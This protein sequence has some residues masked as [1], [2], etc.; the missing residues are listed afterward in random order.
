MYD[1]KRLS[2]TAFQEIVLNETSGMSVS[3]CLFARYVI[4]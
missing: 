4:Q 3:F 1:Q 2:F